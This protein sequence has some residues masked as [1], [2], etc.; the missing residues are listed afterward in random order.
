MMH[1]ALPFLIAP[2]FVLAPVHVSTQAAP[3]NPDAGDPRIEKIL[4]AISPDRLREIDTKLVSFG[5]RN[6]LSDADNPTRGI[7]AARQWIFDEMKRSSPRLQVSFDTYTIAPQGRIT[8]QV[9]L[10]DIVA[11][12]PGKTARRIYVTGH[13]DSL[14]LGRGGQG[15]FNGRRGQPGERAGTEGAGGRRGAGAPAPRTD[16]Q[17]RP[18]QDY[19]VDAPGANDDGSGTSLTMELARVFGQ[20]GVDFDATLVFMCV[21]GE[22]QGLIGSRAHVQKL[23]ADHVV[24]DA[25]FNNDIVGN[26]HGGNG[27]VNEETLRIYS[28]GPADSASRALARYAARAAA[29]YVPSHHIELMARVDRFGRGSDHSSFNAHGYPAIVFR[30]AN[31]NFTKQH[32]ADDTLD[33]VDF[34]YLAQNA[35]INAAGVASLALAPPAPQVN[36]ARGRP[37]LGRQPSG[38]DANLRW[39]ASPGAVAYRLYWRAA[40]S[41][42]WQHTQTVGDLTQYVLPNVNIDDYVFGVSAIGPDGHESVVS[43]YVSPDR[44]ET[45]VKIVQ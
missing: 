34:D 13:Y 10:R 14:N 38:Y 28:Q 16:P 22:E 11:V 15:A 36:N 3:P 18:N 19:N 25:D 30:E 31:E 40:W 9:E 7:G 32:S 42:D 24:V 43:A 2:F 29:L 23:A 39:T 20:S 12:L 5:T 41:N 1:R 33:G 6:T 21:A 4:A 17:M 37:L 45:D 44:Q 8:R 26:S 35:R 27:I